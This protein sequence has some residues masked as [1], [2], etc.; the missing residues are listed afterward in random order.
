MIYRTTSAGDVIA[1]IHRDFGNTITLGD[2]QQDA[3]EW[4]GEAL[5]FIGAGIQLEK[6]SDVLEI[7]SYKS[8]LPSDLIQLIEVFYAPGADVEADV[9]NADKYVLNRSASSAHQGIHTDVRDEEPFVHGESYQLNPDYIH[10]TF[11]TGF[12]GVTYLGLPIDA[13]GYPLVPDNVSYKQALTWYVIRMLML[14]GWKHPA[15]L[16]FPFVDAQWKNYC[17]QARNKANMPDIGSYD[18][19]L[20]IWR[21]LTPDVD[22]RHEYFDEHDVRNLNEENYGNEGVI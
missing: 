17:T 20:H 18:R 1:K 13:N 19:F 14:R 15:G 16:D 12:I 11:E 2:W 8:I 3:L 21:R 6:K 5:E 7:V 4:M 22:A 9:P 10:T